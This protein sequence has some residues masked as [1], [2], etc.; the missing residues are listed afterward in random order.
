VQP[1]QVDR[2]EQASRAQGP[3]WVEVPDVSVGLGL[4]VPVAAPVPVLV[5]AVLGELDR[6]DGG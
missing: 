6:M 2:G 3:G 4:S 5:S 1:R